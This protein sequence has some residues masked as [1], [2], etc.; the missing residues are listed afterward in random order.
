MQVLLLHSFVYNS[1][2]HAQHS[3]NPDAKRA[4]N[5]SRTSKN[6]NKLKMMI[7]LRMKKD[8][9]ER[10]ASDENVSGRRKGSA[11]VDD[12]ESVNLSFSM[13]VRR[14]RM[15]RQM[16][17]AATTTSEAYASRSERQPVSNGKAGPK[18]RKEPAPFYCN[19]P[20]GFVG[21]EAVARMVRSTMPNSMER[22]LPRIYAHS[23]PYR[24]DGVFLDMPEME[25]ITQFRNEIVLV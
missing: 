17:A 20:Q 13:V 18:E 12:G 6:R 21:N 22:F 5:C 11:M 8:I 14:M 23:S 19:L 1:V 15:L 10:A 16:P 4:N 7:M 24:C 2:E 3:I 9:K 25:N